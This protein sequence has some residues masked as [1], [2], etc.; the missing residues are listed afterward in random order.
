[1]SKDDEIISTLEYDKTHPVY[2]KIKKNF[3]NN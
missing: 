1:M 2:M 3:Q